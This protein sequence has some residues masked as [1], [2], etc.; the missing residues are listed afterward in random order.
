MAKPDCYLRGVDGAADLEALSDPTTSRP[1][2]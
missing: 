1:L 2:A